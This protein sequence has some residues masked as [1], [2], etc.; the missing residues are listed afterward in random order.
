MGGSLQQ[1]KNDTVYLKLYFSPLVAKT[2]FLS[3]RANQVWKAKEKGRAEGGG[4]INPI[5][6]LV[7]VTSHSLCLIYAMR[8]DEMR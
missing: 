2:K 7:A 1:L 4:E 8:C 5:G 3:Q 6:N